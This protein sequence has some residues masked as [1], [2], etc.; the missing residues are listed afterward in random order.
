MAR[1][2]I[3]EHPARWDD[4]KAHVLGS[5]PPGTFDELTRLSPGE[6]APG[7]WWRAEQDG[8]VLGYGWMDQ[9]WGEGQVLVAV[10]AEARGQGVGT[11]IMEHL[12]AEARVRGLRVM[13]N[14]LRPSHPEHARVA[15]WL[16]QLG[17]GGGE[18][19]S[20]RRRA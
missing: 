1:S 6:L 8:Q 11:W 17:F 12:A 15:A 10:A 4:N 3:A 7:E 18:D 19:G 16:T 5:A 13:Y 20:Y 9:V 2:W 14:V